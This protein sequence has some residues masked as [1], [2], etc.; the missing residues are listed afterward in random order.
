MKIKEKDLRRIIR[1]ELLLEARHSKDFLSEGFW[2]DAAKIWVASKSP[3]LLTI[4]IAYNVV[5]RA[6]YYLCK[7][8][9]VDNIAVYAF[10]KYL[11]GK[12]DPLT[13][14][15]F[16]DRGYAPLLKELCEKA[17]ESG[18]WMNYHGDDIAFGII[19]YRTHGRGDLATTWIRSVSNT[20]TKGDD[21]AVCLGAVGLGGVYIC[22]QAG[23]P[24]LGNST[25]LLAPQSR[26]FMGLPPTWRIND[27]FD[28]SRL[29]EE[30][31]KETI[32]KVLKLY[33]DD[34]IEHMVTPKTPM[35]KASAALSYLIGRLTNAASIPVIAG[36]PKKF[37]MRLEFP[38]D[39]F[40]VDIKS[41]TKSPSA[42]CG[43]SD[44]RVQLQRH[45]NLRQADESPYVDDMRKSSKG[46][47]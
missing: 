27:E 12:D 20:G 1:E 18:Y 2:A 34:L 13:F 10:T 41:L 5:I 30:Q 35:A 7:K 14:K 21:L 32:V 4:G 45:F 11:L 33:A 43:E 16:K 46:A 23:N 37:M 8:K 17:L 3:K 25:A 19:D 28:F 39:G 44:V 36:G 26:R 40:E 42:N 38:S 47:R 22:K 29:T 6:L 15:D 9:K 31:R 24:G